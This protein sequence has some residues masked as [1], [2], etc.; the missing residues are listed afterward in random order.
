M[1]TI[2]LGQPSF[3][4]DMA[5]TLREATIDDLPVLLSFEQGVV[6]AERPYNNKIKAGNVH[7][8]DLAAL[9][10]REDSH[11]L[12]AAAGERLVGTGHAT[13]KTSLDYYIHDRHA[14]LGLMYVEPDFR[15]QGIIQE[16]ISQ[17]MQWA[18]GEGVND[19]YL[20]VYAD[21]DPAVRAYEKF[22]F[23][24]NLVEMRLHDRW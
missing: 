4:H 6:E 14:Y 19:F 10:A 20:D 1:V 16:I 22:G 8:Y 18:R 17:L 12:V 13:L 3:G 23:R 9:I 2:M 15:G 21:N 5:V 11:V 7:Y 24:R